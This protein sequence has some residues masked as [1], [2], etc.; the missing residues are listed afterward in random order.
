MKILLASSTALTA[1]LFAASS[2]RAD[3]LAASFPDPTSASH[4]GFQQTTSS[5]LGTTDTSAS[6]PLRRFGWAGVGYYNGAGESFIGF[7]A[8]GALDL[9]AVAPDL[10]LGVLGN[11]A[12][13]LGSDLIIPITLGAE[14]HYDRLPVTLLGGAGFTLIP[15]TGGGSGAAA[16][17]LGLIGMAS[18][19]LPQ[20]RQGAAA[21]AQIQYH[22]MS[23]DFSLFVLDL[24][25]TIGF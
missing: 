5:G 2:A 22:F 1:V 14:V 13:G 15:H 20:I 3:G 19:P 4:F 25:L 21:M 23:Q 16:A 17:G 7:N 8:G 11:V 12:I 6:G 10:P 24:G 18:Y 9:V